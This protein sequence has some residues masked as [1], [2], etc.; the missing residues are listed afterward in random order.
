[1]LNNRRRPAPALLGASVTPAV[2]SGCR[3]GLLDS[4][5]YLQRE[6]ERQQKQPDAVEEERQSNGDRGHGS[7]EPEV[8][9]GRND[10]QQDQQRVSESRDGVESAEE[11]VLAHR[12]AAFAE[13]GGPNVYSI[14]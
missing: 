14:P 6:L 10:N 1:M 5:D 11:S 4:Q 3:D 13:E 9:G 2:H 7:V 8:V 12:A